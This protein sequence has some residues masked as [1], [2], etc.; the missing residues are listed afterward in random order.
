MHERGDTLGLSKSEMRLRA[1]H[2]ARE[3]LRLNHHLTPWQY[4]VEV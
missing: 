1:F 4:S 3:D 2:I